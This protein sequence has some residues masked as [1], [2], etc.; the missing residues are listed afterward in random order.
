MNHSVP[1]LRGHYNLVILLFLHLL[2]LFT[3][4][5]AFGTWKL[6]NHVH[7]RY[8]LLL[9]G[10]SEIPFQDPSTADAKMN[11]L[12]FEAAAA[13]TQQSCTLLGIKSIG[14]DYGLVRT[15][16]ARTVGYE[17]QAIATIVTCNQNATQ[18]A[19]EVVKYGASEQAKQIIVGLPL[20]KN[21]TEAPQSSL[22]RDFALQLACVVMARLGPDVPVFLWDERYT[23]KEAAARMRAASTRTTPNS[24]PGRFLHKLLDADAACIILEH[25]YSENGKGAEHVLVP[26]D[27]KQECLSVW[28]AHKEAEAM[29]KQAELDQRTSRTLRRQEAMERTRK[30]EEDTAK[31]GTLGTSRKKKKKRRNPRGTW[32][33]L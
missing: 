9:G 23:S 22:T 24:T 12:L 1:Q 27:V 8:H 25:Y 3:L 30:W 20:Y 29:Q 7:G 15:G 28:K 6:R 18:V 33:I 4:S 5:S 11:A 17:P 16:V 31:E 32:T 14:V 13:S 26:D 19:H 10:T 2:A 21:G